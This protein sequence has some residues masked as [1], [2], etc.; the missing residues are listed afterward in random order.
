MSACNVL[1]AVQQRLVHLKKVLC[2][3]PTW[4]DASSMDTYMYRGSLARVRSVGP[5]RCLM[6]WGTLEC[7]ACRPILEMGFRMGPCNAGTHAQSMM[8]EVCTKSCVHCVVGPQ[9]CYSALPA[10][11]FLNWLHNMVLTLEP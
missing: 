3:L 10:P 6:W 2:R 7:M 4:E 1:K 11:I 8:R 9:A 5:P